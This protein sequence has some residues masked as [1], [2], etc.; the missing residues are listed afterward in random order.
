MEMDNRPVMGGAPVLRPCD[1]AFVETSLGTMVEPFT[2][3]FARKGNGAVDTNYN[4]TDEMNMV[5]EIQYI[6]LDKVTSILSPGGVHSAQVSM[7]VGR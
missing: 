3:P 4:A 7:R 6:S 5:N 1:W 2:A